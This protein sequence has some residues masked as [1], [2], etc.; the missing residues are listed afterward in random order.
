MHARIE[1]VDLVQHL[2]FGCHGQL[3]AAVLQCA[4]V[5]QDHVPESR[6]DFARKRLAHE[7]RHFRRLGGEH[8]EAELD[9]ADELTFVRIGKRA[10]VAEFLRLARIVQEDAHEDE[11][12]EQSADVSMVHL[13]TGRAGGEAGHE[14]FVAEEAFGERAEVRAG[15]FEQVVA[16]AGGELADVLF[17]AGKE[18][19]EFDRF[20]FGFFNARQDDLQCAVEAL[21]LAFDGNEVAVL[22]L[23]EDRFAGVP[24]ASRH[25]TRAIAQFDLHVWVAVLIDAELLLGGEV[26]LVERIGIAELIDKP[27]AHGVPCIGRKGVSYGILET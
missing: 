20:R 26:N 7:V 14:L 16:Q 12:F 3:R 17:G 4:M 25:A 18:V 15:Q 27:P 23:A 2:G 10:S 1:Y 13:D 6:I 21:H 5:T 24:H 19:R 8:F 22:E 9:V 11:M